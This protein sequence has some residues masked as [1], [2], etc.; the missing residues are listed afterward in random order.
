MV[1]FEALY[2]R[3]EIEEE[4]MLIHNSFKSPKKRNLT[5][6]RSNGKSRTNEAI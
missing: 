1:L 4:R 6:Y 5:K 2:Y 3:L